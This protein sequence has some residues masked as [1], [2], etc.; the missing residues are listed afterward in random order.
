[1]HYADGKEVK[2]GDLAISAPPHQGQ[3]NV[4][5]LLGIVVGGNTTADSCNVQLW[6]LAARTCSS[7]GTSGWQKM[8][9]MNPWCVSAK[10]CTLVD[11]TEAPPTV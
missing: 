6:P 5:H 10:E 9:T 3:Q 2:V 7:I 8:E 1:M 11:R 4:T